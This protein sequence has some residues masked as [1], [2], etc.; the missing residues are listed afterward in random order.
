VLDEVGVLDRERKLRIAVELQQQPLLTRRRGTAIKT[1]FANLQHTL[2]GAIGNVKLPRGAVFDGGV[3]DD[4]SAEKIADGDSVFARLIARVVDRYIVEREIRDGVTEDRRVAGVADTDAG[5]AHVRR[6]GQINRRAAVERLVRGQRR[7][8]WRRIHGRRVVF[9]GEIVQR[10]AGRLHDADAS[11]GDV[12]HRSGSDAKGA[13]RVL[14][15]DA[16]LDIRTSPIDRRGLEKDGDRGVRD[17]D[18]RGFRG[19]HR[20]FRRRQCYA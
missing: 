16:A 9:E 1:R 10:D 2:T 15:R 17:V 18:R 19:R 3:G 5:E 13:R 14:E 8:G 20:R 12:P 7:A 11:L 4:G 6:V